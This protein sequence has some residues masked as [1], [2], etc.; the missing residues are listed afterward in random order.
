MRITFLT[1]HLFVFLC[2]SLPASAQSVDDFDRAKHLYETGNQAVAT[3]NF[4]VAIERYTQAIALHPWVP[5]FYFNRAVA[6]RGTRRFD[7]AIKD[8]EKVIELNPKLPMPAWVELYL[9]LGTV[10]QENGEYA[11]ALD[12]LDKALRLDPSNT[13][14][15]LNRGNTHFFLKNFDRALVDINKSLE[16]KEIP[17]GYYSRAKVLEAIGET[18]K[19]IIDYTKAVEL[20]GQFAEAYSNRGLLYGKKRSVES[21]LKDFTRAISIDPLDGIYYFNRANI[22]VVQNRLVLA[23]AD[24]TKAI[25]IYPRWAEPL[26]RRAEANR[27]LGKENLA[28]ADLQKVKEVEKEG[29]DPANKIELIK[30]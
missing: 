12:N 4:T 11:R 13:K 22:Y 10:Y 5:E 26:R 15:F 8:F 2:Y 21:A 7:L 29:F 30:P 18:D 27:R 20:N 23:I 24:Y 16:L 17:L 9:G 19:A 3:S 6:Y 25:E 1:A 28:D 14:I